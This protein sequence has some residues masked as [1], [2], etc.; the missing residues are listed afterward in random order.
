MHGLLMLSL[1]GALPAPAPAP[2]PTDTWRARPK[3]CVIEHDPIIEAR[4][5]KRLHEVFGWNDPSELAQAYIEDIKEAS[6][7]LVEYRIVRRYIVD[8]YPIKKDGFRYDD[9]TYLGAWEDRRFHEPD[10][11]DY[12]AIIEQFNLVRQVQRGRVDEVWLFGAPYFGYWESTMVGDGAYWCNS[13]PVEGVRCRRLFCIMGFNYERGVG[14]M[15]EDLGH[16]TESIMWHIYGSW[17]AEPTHAWNRFTLHEKA[18][19]GQAAC[20]NVHYAPNSESDYDWGNERYVQSTCDDWYT[21]PELTGEARR[22]NCEEWGNGDIRLHHKWWFDHIPRAP[23]KSDGH[24]NN[25]W[26]Y[27]IQFD[28]Y[29]E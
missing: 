4:D 28:K 14:E 16:R 21:Y 15:L 17:E 11:V 7:G 24:W 22:V 12:Q 26:R 18:A 2:R 23:G 19:P 27:I 20:G 1:L 5:G 29:R 25:W 8:G 6:G 13:E 10:G 3:V 9:E